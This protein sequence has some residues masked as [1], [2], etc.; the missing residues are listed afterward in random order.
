MPTQPGQML[1][2]YRLVEKIGEGGMGV[3]WKAVDTKLD[4]EVAIK[5]LAEELAA[6]PERLGRFEREAK[7]VA[8]LDHPNIVTVYS[9]EEAEGVHLIT[10]GLVRGK[11]LTEL[12]PRN[13]LP[14]GKFFDQALALADAISAAHQQGIT[15]RDLKPDNVMIGDDGRL[16]VLDFGIAKLREEARAADGT[17]LP[18]A[19][20]T[21]EGK[22]LGT[23]SYM[24]PEQAE[25]KQVDH[26]SDI[27]SLG[28]ML[29]QMATGQRPFKGDTSVSIISSIIKDTPASVTDIKS[30]LPRDLGRIVRRCLAKEPMDRFQS[31][32]GLRSELVALKQE[33]DSGEREPRVAAVSTASSFRRRWVLSATVLAVVVLLVWLGQLLIQQSCRDPDDRYFAQAVG[34]VER[35]RIVVLPFE[36]LGPPEDEYFAAGMTEE[37][38]SRL[39]VVSGLGVISRT[40]AFQY[41]RTGKNIKQVGEDLGVDYVL[42]GTVRWARQADASRVRIT[43]QL[44][45][46]ADDTHLWAEAYERVIEDIFQVQ[47]EIAGEVIE[48]LGVALLEPERRAIESKPTDNPEAYNAYLRGL[49]LMSQLDNPDR[50][51]RL[52]IE[53]FRRAVELDPNFTL[54]Y[55]ELSEAHSVM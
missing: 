35:K 55:A 46:V 32:I 29:Y 44:I 8:A 33:L 21:Q 11:S 37:I 9:V 20:V 18:T 53:M 51:L 19:T 14:L 6:D 10:M 41:D 15:H 45:R 34:A 5:T 22:I 4:R 16:K 52:G 28:V 31:A 49:H 17:Q 50:N 3:V 13:G 25:G 7:A 24:S 36:N 47:S 2:H 1:S 43:P 39:A 12:I 48:Q 38:T 54:A 42:E 27:F 23:V 26:R 40:S 30:S